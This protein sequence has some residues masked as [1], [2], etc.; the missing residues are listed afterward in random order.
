MGNLIYTAI[1]SLDGFTEDE[2]GHFDWAT[3][4]EEVHAFVNELERPIGTYLYGRRM[5]ET[6]V[7]WEKAATGDNQSPIFRDYAEIWRGAEKIVFSRTLGTASSARTRIEGRFDTEMIRQTKSSAKSDLSIG[8]AEFAALAFRAN[9]ID[10]CPLFL[11]PIVV[12]GGKRALPSKVR[13]RLAFLHEER[14]R[15]GV[16]HLHYRVTN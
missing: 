6:M 2:D 16:V 1:T 9:L 11:N 10:E 12:G 7:F 3:P 13:T 8:G 5:Y 4:D 14:V 15:N